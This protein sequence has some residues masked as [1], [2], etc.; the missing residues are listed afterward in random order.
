MHECANGNEWCM[1]YHS[2][3]G[4]GGN[5]LPILDPA[6]VCRVKATQ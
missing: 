1:G 6:A 2:G 3:L 4:L 5:A